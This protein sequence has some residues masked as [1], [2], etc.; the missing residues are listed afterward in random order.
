MQHLVQP[1]AGEFCP[2][3]GALASHAEDAEKHVRVHEF[4]TARAARDVL[5][6]DDTLKGHVLER[7]A[8]ARCA[9]FWLLLHVVSLPPRSESTP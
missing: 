7:G 3:L 4:L 6:V 1:G 8:L 5:D 2:A 9:R